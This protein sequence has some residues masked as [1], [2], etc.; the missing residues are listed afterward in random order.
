MA[1]QAF[2]ALKNVVVARGGIEI[3]KG[4][5]LAIPEGSITAVVG[6]SG[7]GKTT[8]LR[9]I[10]GL[11]VP[12]S[13]SVTVADAGSLRNSSALRRHRRRTAT[14]F[15]D[16]A[17]IERLSALDNVMLGL[18][19][20]RHPLSLSPWP[21]SMRL[22]AARALDDVGLLHRANQRV[23]RLSGGERQ[24][25]GVARALV[26]RPRLLLA[27]EPFSSIDPAWAR[28]IGQQFGEL[29][30]RTALTLVIVLHQIETALAM[31]DQVIGLAGGRVAF[32]GSPQAFDSAAQQRLFCNE[33]VKEEL[34]A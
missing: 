3:L 7:A 30:K 20:Q 4:V 33:G 23:S 27:D 17:L 29:T 10:N 31:A 22:R 8:V 15:Q 2:V 24:R 28:R 34:H 25:V 14:V 32:R 26:R 9:V 21:G 18:A 13:G 1:Q 6:S 11:T 16:H 12:D 19:D 5:S